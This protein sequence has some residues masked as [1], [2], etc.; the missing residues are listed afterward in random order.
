MLKCLLDH[1][2]AD[3]LEGFS[4]LLRRFCFIY[5]HLNVLYSQYIR[6]RFA[7]HKKTLIREQKSALFIK[8]KSV[9]R[10][11]SGYIFVLKHY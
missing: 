5:L 9:L 4:L 3:S 6:Y 10:F 2:Y 1:K 8:Y 11:S 7:I